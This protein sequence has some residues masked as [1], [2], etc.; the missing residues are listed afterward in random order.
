MRFKKRLTEDLNTSYLEAAES[1]D[2]IE[3]EDRDILKEYF[4]MPNFVIGDEA[5]DFRLGGKQLK[6]FKEFMAKE[7]NLEVDKIGNIEFSNTGGSWKDLGEHVISYEYDGEKVKVKDILIGYSGEVLDEETEEYIIKKLF[8]YFKQI[9]KGQDEAKIKAK[10]KKEWQ[11]ALD[12][13]YITMGDI[14]SSFYCDRS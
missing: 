10:A 3:D 5:E 1:F 7:L 9:Q 12:D 8:K 13:G 6:Q 4:G 14:S 2:D 11:F